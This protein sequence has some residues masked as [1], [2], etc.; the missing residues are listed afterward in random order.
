MARFQTE[1]VL[2]RAVEFSESDR[3]VHLLT[4]DRGRLTAIAKGARR[5]KKRFGGNLDLFNH[6]RITVERRRRTGMARLEQAI[7]IQPFPAAAGRRP[8]LRPS[9]PTWSS[10]ST[11]SHPRAATAA[12]CA[13]CSTSPWRR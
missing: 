1:A 13:A 4:R 2:L 5:S 9:P 11:G 8:A 10:C 3:I 7:L 6:L 12:I